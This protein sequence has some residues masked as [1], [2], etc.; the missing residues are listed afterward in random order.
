M[1]TN[2]MNTEVGAR[3]KSLYTACA[4]YGDDAAS[5]AH[6][7]PK[8]EIV[9]LSVVFYRATKH[10]AYRIATLADGSEW[11]AVKYRAT[12]EH[13]VREWQPVFSAARLERL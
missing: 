7:R 5:G 10:A 3:I 8:F 12:K 9:A 2:A 4:V 11:L 13:P 1:M 6:M